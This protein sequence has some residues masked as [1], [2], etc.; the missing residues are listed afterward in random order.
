MLSKMRVEE[1]P[2]I[3]ESLFILE[4]AGGDWAVLWAFSVEELARGASLK[5][6]TNEFIKS[7]VN[8]SGWHPDKSDIQTALNKNIEKFRGLIE[9]HLD[10]LLLVKG[11]PDE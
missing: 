8:V 10:R 2:S 4:L 11:E 9:D 3:G 1:D 6:K 5:G 7:M